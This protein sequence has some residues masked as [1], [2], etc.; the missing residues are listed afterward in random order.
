MNA[1]PNQSYASPPHAAEA[2]AKLTF[3]AGVLMVLAV[4]LYFASAQWLP[5][6]RPP[7]DFSGF[8]LGR[9]FFNT[10]MGGRSAFA[11]GPGPWF[12]FAPYNAALKE[13]A[14]RADLPPYHW[15][16]PPHLILFIWP[17]GLL[18]YVLAYVAWSLAGLALYLWATWSAGVTRKDDMAFV[19]VA[20][21]VAVN[22]ICG[23]NGFVTAALLI[24]GL[25]NLDRRPVISGLL[26]GIL[27]IKPQ[28]GLLLPVLLLVTG[29]WR[30]IASAVA[31]TVVL[32]AAT[33]FW[34]GPDIWLDFFHKVMPQQQQFILDAGRFGWAAVSSVFVDARRIGLPVN[35]AWAVQSAASVAAVTAVI[36]TFWRKRDP[37]LSIAL[38]LT[39]GFLVTPY[40]LNYDMVALAYAALLLRQQP[41]NRLADHVLIVAIWILPLVMLPFGLAGVPVAS[42]VLAT[43]AGRLIWRLAVSQDVVAVSPASGYAPPVPAGG[44]AVQ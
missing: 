37:G 3:G 5:L 42:V 27:T 40:M 7:I 34:F 13:I 26:F 29:R 21:A 6:D 35:A 43:F 14:G 9:D 32:A 36:W 8:A 39:A 30:V 16:Y 15:S 23:Q 10:W 12:D 18:P 24:G 33:A 17:L 41:G 22:M 1:A 4:G 2:Y 31:T 44:L 19:A 25:A 38:F 20:P 11:G 28:F